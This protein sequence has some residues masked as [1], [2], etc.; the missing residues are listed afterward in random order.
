MTEGFKIKPNEIES[1]HQKPR[2]KIQTHKTFLDESEDDLYFGCEGSDNYFSSKQRIRDL[3]VIQQKP[4]N[5]IPTHFG[6]QQQNMLWFPKRNTLKLKNE[7]TQA[8]SMFFQAELSN[9]SNLNYQEHSDDNKEED[10]ASLL[11]EIQDTIGVK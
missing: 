7:V 6:Q 2:M 4:F 5:C 11:K 10:E 9:L 3:K 8:E 1:Q